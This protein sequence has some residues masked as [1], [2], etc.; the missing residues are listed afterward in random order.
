QARLWPYQNHYI[1]SMLFIF[2]VFVFINVASAMFMAPFL[3]KML[4][5]IAM[6]LT[7]HY[8]WVFNTTFLASVIG[9]TFLLTDPLVKA[10]Y[11][12][13]CYY[14]DSLKTGQDL[15]S[16]I[17][18]LRAPRIGAVAVIVLLWLAGAPA[19]C[20]DTV[21]DKAWP[22]ILA[23]SPSG[24]DALPS[25]AL[26]AS[27][28]RVLESPVYAWRMPRDIIPEPPELEKG[29]AR[30]FVD[31]VGRVVK[32]FFMEVGRQ[33]DRFVKWLSRKLK[34]KFN[35]ETHSKDSSWDV[36]SLRTM[37]WWFLGAVSRA[38]GGSA[39]AL[40]RHRFRKAKAVILTPLVAAPDLEDENLLASQFPEEE[41]LSL[42]ARFGAEGDF[43][44]AMRALFMA[45]L[46]FLS[47]VELVEIVK[48]KSNHEYHRELAR[49][50]R[51]FPDA[52]PAFYENIRL[53]ER[54]W[55]G[56]YP[57]TKDQLDAFSLNLAKIRTHVQT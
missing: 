7:R 11:T 3:V 49:R 1:I 37:G 47:R 2:K 27:I 10:A 15:L 35:R 30:I 12:L 16:E 8:Y 32:K 9:M 48:S 40:D 55:Y 54:G 41:W 4:L 28:G 45:C 23:E 17:S 26:D 25:D 31:S 18:S 6:P 39:G 21:S 13:R 22:T 44:K 56:L 29:L 33:V 24:K 14:G 36:Q 51:R 43:R 19:V 53:F 57:V 50:G 5:G 38:G 46:A 52:L 20:A 34:W 42:A